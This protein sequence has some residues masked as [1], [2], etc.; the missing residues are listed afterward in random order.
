MYFKKKK[1]TSRHYDVLPK[2]EIKPKRGDT[3]SRKQEV[4]P[5]TDD[6]DSQGN[7]EE[8]L[9]WQ[10]GHTEGLRHAWERFPS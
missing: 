7:G 1:K 9:S 4:K 3:G 8:T 6:G 5:I 2:K 10:P